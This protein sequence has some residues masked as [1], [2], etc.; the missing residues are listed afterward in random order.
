M[1]R[2]EKVAFNVAR[3]KQ[4]ED[5]ENRRRS[6]ISASLSRPK[7]DP[8]PRSFEPEPEPMSPQAPPSKPIGPTHEPQTWMP[9]S[10]RKR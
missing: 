6:Q 3:L 9:R 10:S 1:A 7:L 5:E 2:Q 4:K 8:S